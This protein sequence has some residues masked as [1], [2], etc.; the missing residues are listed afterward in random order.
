MYFVSAV[1]GHLL[2]LLR[3]FFA[4]QRCAV[5]DAKGTLEVKLL[6]QRKQATWPGATSVK[7]ENRIKKK[8]ETVS[9]SQST[10]VKTEERESALLAAAFR[11]LPSSSVSRR[12]IVDCGLWS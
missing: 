5:T 2:L 1:R 4:G 10:P 8:M 9:L 3:V 7:M 6:T 11:A 12:G